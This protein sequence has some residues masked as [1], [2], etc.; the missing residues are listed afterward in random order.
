MNDSR[1]KQEFAII[2]SLL[3]VR[4]KEM[5]RFFLQLGVL[6]SNVV[7]CLIFVFFYLLYKADNKY[8]VLSFFAILIFSI[9]QYRTDRSFLRLLFFC[10][11][12]LFLLE[13][14]LIGLPFFLVSFLKGELIQVGG[15]VLFATVMPFLKTVQATGHWVIRLPF[16]F[17]GGV[18]MLYAVRV[19]WYFL[20]IICAGAIMGCYYDNVNL[21][22]VCA[23]FYIWVLGGSMRDPKPLIKHYVSFKQFLVMNMRMLVHNLPLLFLPVLCCLI[24]IESTFALPF[25]L[26][27]G[28][29]LF[30][31]TFLLARYVTD[32]DIILIFHLLFILFLNS[33]TIIS[34]WGGVTFLVIIL[35]YVL[36]IKNKYGYLWK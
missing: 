24:Y 19:S 13:Y 22:R 27:L 17:R 8:L 16:M 2:S 9:N 11:S 5:Y 12:F 26:L 21:V 1:Q 29:V 34:I 10:P 3:T 30:V 28:G 4:W 18:D 32:N 23:I 35:F 36:N 14:I 25:R 20:C 7:V 33:I 6:L 15:M 31:I